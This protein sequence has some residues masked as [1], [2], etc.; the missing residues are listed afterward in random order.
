MT[1]RKTIHLFILCFALLLLAACGKSG[2]PT[3]TNTDST[4]ET[5]VSPDISNQN[6]KAFCEDTLGHVWMATF[7]GVDKFDGHEYH[8]YFCTDD[9]TGLVDNN[10]NTLF[11][12]SRG[13][14]WVGTVNGPCRYTDQDRFERAGWTSENRNVGQFLET[15]DGRILAYNVSQ[16]MEYDE[17]ANRFVVKID[18]ILSWKTYSGRCKIVNGML[19]VATSDCLRRYDLRDYSLRDS[20]AVPE[21]V[22][23]FNF[24]DDGTLWLSGPN[25]IARYSLLKRTYEPVAAT[26]TE[27]LTHHDDGIS[28]IHPYGHG[29]LLSTTRG[30]IYY[31]DSIADRLYSRTDALFPFELPTTQIN[32]FFTD[33]HGNL[34]IGTLDKGAICIYRH[35]K[36]TNNAD[37]LNRYLNHQS[38]KSVATDSHSNLFIAS[39]PGGLHVYN[40]A[41]RQAKPLTLQTPTADKD[42]RALHLYVDR[43]GDLWVG[44]FDAVLQCSFDGS[45]LSVKNRWDIFAPLDFA[46]DPSGTMWVT[47]SSVF[48]YPL[49]RDGTREQIQLLPFGFTFVPCI[50][51]MDD[52]QLLVAP[53]NHAPMVINPKTRQFTELEIAK[54]DLEACIRRSVIIPVATKRASNG[55][56]WFGVNTNGVMVYSPRT[57][58]L[59]S[60]GGLTCNDI[61]AIEEAQ[62][63]TMWIST[64][65]GLNCY[66]PRTKQATHYYKDQG[67]GGNQFIDRSAC[68]LAD[69]TLVFG[70]THGLTFFHPNDHGEQRHAPL[71][72]EYLKIHNEVVRPG[73]PELAQNLESCDDIYLRY[74]QNSFSITY[75]SLDYNDQQR[76]HYQY[77]MDG[78]DDDWHDAGSDHTAYYA[79]LPAGCYTFHV[80]TSNDGREIE[81][82]TSVRV[83][84]APHPLLSWWAKIVYALIAAAIGYYIYKVRQRIAAQKLATRKAEMERE[85]EARVNQMNMSFFANVSHEFRTPLTMIS[86]PTD[87]LAHDT[88]LSAESRRM[89]EIIQ[90]SVRR[91]LR[92]VNQLMDFNKLEN[93]TLRLHV[94]Q[95]D[96]VDALR[97]IT[98]V[99]A[100][101]MQEKGITLRLEG[102]DEPLTMWFDD[103]KLDK[104]VGNLLSNALKFTP[105]GGTITL[106]IDADSRFVT[107]SVADT[108]TGI[109][110]SQL[111]DIFRRYY[112]VDN[113]TKGTINWGTGIGLYYARRLATLHHGTLTAANQPTGTGAVFT[114]RLPTDAEAYAD[115]ERAAV[116]SE[117]T[118]V[119]PLAETVQQDG[120]DEDNDGRDTIM[121][122][123][124]DTEIANYL[125]ALLSPHYHVMAHFDADSALQAMT[126]RQPSLILSD[127]MMPGKDGFELCREVKADRMLCHIPVILVTAKATTD[128]QIEGL[129]TGADAYVTKPF[130]PTVLLAQIRSLLTNRQRARQVLG[131]ATQADKK[132]EEVLSPQDKVFMDELYQ[133]MEAELSNSELDIISITERLHISRTKFYYKIKGLTGETPATFFRTF[134][135]NR[136]AQ[137][138]KTGR[139]NVSEVTYMTGFSTQS[140]FATLFK[141]QFGMTPTEY[142][143]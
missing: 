11:R 14:I 95:T 106:S 105:R 72:L 80:H 62:D 21:G 88:T 52:G 31:Y 140:H 119:Y 74:D 56:I 3:H 122:V 66:D 101:N 44:T 133:I 67:T 5:L 92:L 23:Y 36:N 141:K 87:M 8:Q 76:T 7:R 77:R 47:T 59:T 96:L 113:Q 48:V 34:W 83:H 60:V 116:P 45:Q 139:H 30:N 130:V 46:E 97:R 127:V 12:D 6:V 78:V 2:K 17:A 135:L 132:V 93:D 109:P 4:P 43:E 9:S 138:L 126:E 104:I 129:N 124:D 32:R 112:Q 58:R 50:T 110:E 143:G 114:L 28:L 68:R 117:Q 1:S 81:A 54:G 79:N 15:G 16:V 69:G 33:S 82:T 26:L 142:M 128:N 108:G 13:R 64:M 123:D 42:N 86:G 85:Q 18:S 70:G 125:H 24:Q 100:F 107:I 38:V 89:V 71:V 63:G 137:L 98:E 121:V 73:G 57:H 22:Y 55:D 131:Q 10:V 111:E 134:K 65:N 102:L 29:L 90:R 136:A 39:M 49:H 41:N 35:N 118:V 120:P 115:N 51:M 75:A 19:W 103:D 84:I 37:Y 61:T 91:M 99:F 40:T 27:R 20:V 94:E 53:F 25:T